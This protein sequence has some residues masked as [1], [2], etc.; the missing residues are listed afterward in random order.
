MC[1]I[2]GYEVV[3]FINGTTKEIKLKDADG[4]KFDLSEN[5]A[6][7]VIDTPKLK[8][9]NA[10]EFGLVFKA[11]K[12]SPRNFK[13][14]VDNNSTVPIKLHWCIEPNQVGIYSDVPIKTKAHS[15]SEL[16]KFTIETSEFKLLLRPEDLLGISDTVSLIF[17]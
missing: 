8:S 15:Y 7:L 13:V 4:I 17:K 10:K 16:E 1:K 12:S 2:Y 5:T 6:S 3:P 11:V 14:R 9:I